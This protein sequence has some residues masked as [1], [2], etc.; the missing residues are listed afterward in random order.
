MEQLY[1][2]CMDE[3]RVGDAEVKREGLYLRIRCVC[4]LPKDKRFR[5]FL[6]S[7]N[8]ELDLGLCASENG[9]AEVTAR[10]SIKNAGVGPYTFVIQ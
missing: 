8:G 6:C 4:K 5:L 10:V 3:R 1:S 7:K 2:V 9:Y